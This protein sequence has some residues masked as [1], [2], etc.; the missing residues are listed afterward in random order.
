LSGTSESSPVFE[1]LFGIGGGTRV[2][3]VFGDPIEHS[4]SPPIHNAA[5]RSLGMHYVYVAFHVRRSELARA[6]AGIKALGIAGVNVTIPH[7]TSVIRFL[8]TIEK[9]AREIGAVNT[10]TR[11]GHGLRGYNT[12][13]QAAL[14]V[15]QKLGGSLSGTKATIL[16]AGGAARAIAYYL[17]NTIESISILN[18]TRAKGS[19]L[20]NEITRWSGN[21]CRSYQLNNANLR[22]E[23][24]ESDILINTLPVQAFPRFAKTLIQERL[25]RPGMI[26]FDANYHQESS[27]LA[28]AQSAGAKV[29]DGLDML[30]SQA[31]LSFELWTGRKPPIDVMHEAALKA[32]QAR[33]R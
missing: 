25:V 18:R 13:G 11:S 26:I 24:S 16:G 15:L 30:V 3:A 28:D 10:I 27:F 1:E 19:N 22:K 2:C 20:A 21:K 31:A 23:T 8:D 29:S 12:D 17:S 9:T 5:F 6:I 32:K 33:M 14:E 4:L 7:K